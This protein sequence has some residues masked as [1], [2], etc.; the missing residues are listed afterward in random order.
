M[1]WPG[2]GRSADQPAS[3]HRSADPLHWMA[4]PIAVQAPTAA[5]GLPFASLTPSRR[6]HSACLELMCDVDAS[7]PGSLSTGR[8]A[9]TTSRSAWSTHARRGPRR[10]T[11][12]VNWPPPCWADRRR[13]ARPRGCPPRPGQHLQPPP[14]PAGHESVGAR[15]VQQ[16]PHAHP[17]DGL[18][19]E[20]GGASSAQVAAR[21]DQYASPGNPHTPRAPAGPAARPTRPPATAATPR[22]MLGRVRLRLATPAGRRRTER[23]AGTAGHNQPQRAPSP[24]A[25][26]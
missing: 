6:A 10:S 13:P 20:R 9:P 8:P 3:Q 1:A 23:R 17:A 7:P 16:P 19:A 2:S 25:I 12:G 21:T 5:P 24:R 14:A 26:A 11:S 18:T 4:G 22:A 15:R